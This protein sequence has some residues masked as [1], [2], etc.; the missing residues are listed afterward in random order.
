[1]SCY[2]KGFQLRVLVERCAHSVDAVGP[3]LIFEQCLQL[4]RVGRL[5]QYVLAK[6]HPKDAFV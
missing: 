1:M 2:G 5:E 6:F 3:V 4:R